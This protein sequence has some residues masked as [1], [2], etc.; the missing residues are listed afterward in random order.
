MNI[1]F[2]L[3]RELDTIKAKATTLFNLV[4]QSRYIRTEAKL[5]NI[6]PSKT[7]TITACLSVL[8]EF[9]G[10]FRLSTFILCCCMSMCSAKEFRQRIY[11]VC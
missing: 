10:S 3:P 4:I 8:S 5:L 2:H 11:K 9:N 1:I 7:V 6:C